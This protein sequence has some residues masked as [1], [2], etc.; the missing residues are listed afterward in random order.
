[1]PFF[2]I[3]HRRFAGLDDVFGARTAAAGFIGT[4]CPVISQSNSMR[5]A[6]SCCFTPGAPCVCCSS[7]TQ[8]ATSNG[9]IAVSESPRFSHQAKNRLHA[10]IGPPRVIVV[11]VGR[12][13]FD[14]APVGL[15]AEVGD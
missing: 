12:E 14:V 13:E 11:D 4:I 7:L 6:A 3:E 9:R 2:A 5:T 10:R 15:V 1:M 8:A